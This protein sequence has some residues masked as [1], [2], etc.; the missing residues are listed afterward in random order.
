M[1]QHLLRADPFPRIRLQ[2][3]PQKVHRHR[4]HIAVKITVQVELQPPVVLVQLLK[5]PPLEERPTDQEDVENGSC[6]EDIAD[7]A[8]S[9]PL[10]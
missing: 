2:H 1:P 9:L 10:D 3:P 4:V 7:R 5:L 8:H 6:R